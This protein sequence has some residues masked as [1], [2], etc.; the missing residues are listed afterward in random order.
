MKFVTALLLLAVANAQDTPVEETPD[1]GTPDEGTPDEGT[2]EEESAES[3]ANKIAE[4]KGENAFVSCANDVACEQIGGADAECGKI[5]IYQTEGEGDAA[6]AKEGGK[7]E[8]FENVCVLK[9]KCNTDVDLSDGQID[10]ICS[11]TKL[12]SAMFAAATVAYVM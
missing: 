7:S 5:K 11:A 6:V 8:T 2:P 10:T 4:Y 1:E 12:M 9:S 3:V